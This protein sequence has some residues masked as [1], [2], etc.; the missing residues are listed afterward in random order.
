MTTTVN[1]EIVFVENERFMNKQE[2]KTKK[3]KRIPNI[4]KN[5]NDDSIKIIN[6]SKISNKINILFYIGNITFNYIFVCNV[7]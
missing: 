3:L 6:V 5:T 1:R 4:Y 7:L 2:I